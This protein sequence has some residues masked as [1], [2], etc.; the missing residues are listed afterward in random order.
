MELFTYFYPGWSRQRALNEW[1]IVEGAKSLLRGH[2][3]PRVPLKKG[4][5]EDSSYIEDAITVARKAKIS[6]FIFLLYWD[7]GVVFGDRPILDFLSKCEKDVD[8]K[9]S[10]MWVNRKLHHSFP[11]ISPYLHRYE[12]SPDRLVGTTFSDFSNLLVYLQKFF[13]HRCYLKLFDRPIFQIY[14]MRSL[15][16]DL[17]LWRLDEETRFS[18]MLSS[19]SF[20]PTIPNHTIWPWM[21]DLPLAACATSNYVLLPEFGGSGLQDYRDCCGDAFIS[22]DRFKNN[23]GLPHIPSITV[24]WDPTPRS[25]E[26]ILSTN[27]R[28]RSY[29]RWPVVFGSTPALVR[30][31]LESGMLYAR[32]T[33][34]NLV[35]IS[36]LNEWSEGHFIEPEESDGEILIRE[37]RNAQ[38]PFEL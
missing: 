37:I 22:W 31:H 13:D 3:Q 1:E 9:F 23:T 18:G 26:S 16:G 25:S 15:Y 32:D 6:G 20:V 35:F 27:I 10:I 33:G 34:T 8:L 7:N 12:P 21:R 24:G 38:R 36:S 2:R 19:L 30:R 28:T 11:V 29:P 14:D 4:Y 17:K 5:I